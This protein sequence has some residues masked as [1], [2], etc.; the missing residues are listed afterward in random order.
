MSSSTLLARLEGNDRAA[1]EELAGALT[2][3]DNAGRK[4]AEEFYKD[5]LK[6]KPD[7]ALRYLVS[8]LSHANGEMKQFCCVYLRKVRPL[9]RWGWRPTMTAR[10]LARSRART[11]SR[12]NSS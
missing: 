8:G 6:H 11:R 12:D 9:A 4:Q 5:L 2:S 1:F 10:A 7:I 3:Q